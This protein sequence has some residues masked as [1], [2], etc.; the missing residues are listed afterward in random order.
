MRNCPGKCSRR[1]G[2]SKR[3]SLSVEPHQSQ[4]T[5]SHLS[6]VNLSLPYLARRACLRARIQPSALGVLNRT[7]QASFRQLSAASVFQLPA[8]QGCKAFSNAAP[9]IRQHSR[10]AFEA[11][12]DRYPDQETPQHPRGKTIVFS[13]E[14]HCVSTQKPP[15]LRR[16]LSQ[17]H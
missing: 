3:S 9:E 10:L 6:S 15:L 2:P 1:S 7:L 14:K 13:I 4:A 12:S 16:A 11:F 17:C 5:F 8:L